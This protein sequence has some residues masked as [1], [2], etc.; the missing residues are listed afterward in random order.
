MASLQSKY[1]TETTDL[2]K[3][4]EDSIANYEVLKLEKGD[5]EHS[6]AEYQRRLFER[7]KEI[8]DLTN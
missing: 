5:A 4:L 6:N 1:T 7:E 3:K 2:K 8:E